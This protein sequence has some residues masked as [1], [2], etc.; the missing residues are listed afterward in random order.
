MSG[1]KLYDTG[2]NSTKTSIGPKSLG[3]RVQRHIKMKGLG[4]FEIDIQY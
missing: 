2:H 1:Y 4:N 3:T